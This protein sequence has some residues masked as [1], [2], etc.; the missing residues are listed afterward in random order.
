M[1]ERL[2]EA[3][4]TLVSVSLDRRLPGILRMVALVEMP[5]LWE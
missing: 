3:P 1:V 4:A 2:P 5:E